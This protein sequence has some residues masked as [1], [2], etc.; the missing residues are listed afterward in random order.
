MDRALV[1]ETCASGDWVTQ[2]KC[3]GFHRRLAGQLDRLQA[4]CTLATGYEQAVAGI[5]LDDLAGCARA[6]SWLCAMHF[7]RLSGKR[8]KRTGKGIKAADAVVDKDCR[9]RPF[10]PS[11]FFAQLG[12]AGDAATVLG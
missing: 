3:A 4:E 5:G 12:C 1:A 11:V 10:N 6:M 7:E 2:Q 8:G 9:L